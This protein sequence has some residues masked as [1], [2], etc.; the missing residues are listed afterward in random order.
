MRNKAYL[1]ILAIFIFITLD[2]GL[3]KILLLKHI[4]EDP[5]IFLKIL[6][7]MFTSYGVIQWTS[8]GMRLKTVRF[9]LL[10]EVLLV[11]VYKYSQI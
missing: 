5:K 7:V 9:W 1:L 11:L 8:N 3:E 2:M 6:I 10:S 4:S